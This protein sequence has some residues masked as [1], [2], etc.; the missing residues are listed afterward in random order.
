MG[1]Y[2]LF[3]TVA[4]LSIDFSVVFIQIGILSLER[5]VHKVKKDPTVLLKDEVVLKN[6]V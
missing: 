3:Y 2:F 4:G 6:V 1:N 5:E